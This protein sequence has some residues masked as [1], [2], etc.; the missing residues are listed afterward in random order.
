[1]IVSNILSFMRNSN[2]FTNCYI[3]QIITML[4]QMI[5][6][7]NS[8]RNSYFCRD[9]RLAEASSSSENHSSNGPSNIPAATPPKPAVAS[10][11]EEE[12]SSSEN[13]VRINLPPAT[14][15]DGNADSMSEVLIRDQILERSAGSEAER[16]E[17]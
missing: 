15:S 2:A 6:F 4:L 12:V 7:T 5:T 1:M 14:F 9:G 11:Q 16:K 3:N 10:I 17:L 13:S 8:N